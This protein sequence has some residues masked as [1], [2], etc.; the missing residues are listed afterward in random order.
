M[1][2]LR[3]RFQSPESDVMRPIPRSM[4]APSLNDW[5]S[6]VQDTERAEMWLNK[7]VRFISHSSCL[8][9]SGGVDLVSGVEWKFLVA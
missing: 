9:F 7:I 5:S 2:S 8:E 3:S 4:L 6:D 1:A